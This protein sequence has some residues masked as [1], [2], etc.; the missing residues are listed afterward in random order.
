MDLYLE[1]YM[2]WLDEEYYDNV[3]PNDVE[4]AHKALCEIDR[5]KLQLKDAPPDR[6]DWITATVAA[7]EASIEDIGF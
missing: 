5:L 2:N 7:L 1:R 3:A 4:R 6:V